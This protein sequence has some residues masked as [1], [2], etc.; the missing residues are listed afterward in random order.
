MT[1][2]NAGKVSVLALTAT[3][4]VSSV[5]LFN[6]LTNVFANDEFNVCHLTNSQNNSWVTQQVNANQLQSHL[7]NGDFLY[8]GPLKS[9]GH[10]EN[11]N[12]VDSIWCANHV[13]TAT[14]T[15]TATP[16]PPSC[17]QDEH[18]D[19]SGTKCLKWEVSAPQN[20][21]SAPQGQVLGAST[22]A[23]TGSF[24]ETL[25]QAIMIVGATLS[26]FGFKGLKKT[27]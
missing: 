9:N 8:N 19:L 10:P 15:A 14:A 17:G 18:L 2:L 21:G 26:A 27:K 22:M 20:G 25:Y 6:S 5:L 1:K 16:T 24:D 3:F 13:P 7:A 12:N 11:A 23:G 4:V